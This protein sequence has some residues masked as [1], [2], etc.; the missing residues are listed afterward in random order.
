[1]TIFPRSLR[2]ACLML[3]LAAPW[4]VGAGDA[5]ADEEASRAPV[6]QYRLPEGWSAAQLPDPLRAAVAKAVATVVDPLSPDAQREASR[7]ISGIGAPALPE[8]VAA[9]AQAPWSARAALVGAVAEMDAPE[10]TPLL[11]AAAEDPAF[12]VREAAVVGLGKTGD[13]RAGAV[14]LA[15]SDPAAERVWRVRTVAAEALRRGILRGAVDRSAGEAALVRLLRDPDRDVR[16]SALTAL[17]PLGAPEALEP[18]LALHGALREDKDSPYEE[19]RLV[20]DALRAYRTDDPGVRG[21]LVD[22]FAHDEP[23]I[24]VL[25]AWA[26][27]SVHGAAALDD[28]R[29]A[30]AVLHQLSQDQELGMWEVLAGLGPDAAPWLRARAEQLALR[31]AAHRAEFHENLLLSLVELLV[32]VDEDAGVELLHWFLEGRDA[33]VLDPGTRR[34]ALDKAEAAL[35]HRMGGVLRRFFHAADGRDLRRQTLRALVRSGGD[36]VASFVDEALNSDDDALAREALDLL[37][38]HPEIPAGP[39]LAELARDSGGDL[40]RLALQTLGRRDPVAAAAVAAAS[41]AHPRREMRLE[42]AGVLA[43]ARDPAHFDA[44]LARF[45][46]EDGSDGVPAPDADPPEEADP[47]RPVTLSP[48]VS[49]AERF[50]RILRRDLLRALHGVDPARARPL[51]IESLV[52]EPDP[53]M[54]TAAARLLRE[55]TGDADAALLL[56]RAAKDDDAAVR[57]ELV[58]TLAALGDAQTVVD[59]FSARVADP[60]SRGETLAR[61][62]LSSAR[63]VPAGI[64]EGLD[65]PAW[66]DEHRE[67]ALVIL[68]RA[69]RV[70]EAEKLVALV[71][72]AHTPELTAEALRQ[73]ALRGGDRAEQEMIRLLESIEDPGK[74][75]Q[76]ARAIGEARAV[77]AVPALIAALER[78]RDAAVAAP[79]RVDPAVELYEAAAAA[80]G[81]CGGEPAGRVLLAHLLHPDLVR[82]GA[83]L[84]VLKGGPF[85]ADDPS[86]IPLVKTLVRAFAHLDE[87]AC[88][89]LVS[90]WLAEISADGRDLALDEGYVDGIARYLRDPQAYDLPPRRRPAAALLLH[91]LVLRIAPRLSPIDLE[92]LND[93]SSELSTQGRHEEALA[94]YRS[95]VAQLDVEDAARRPD[96]RTWQ[97]GKLRVLEARVAHAR[98]ETDRALAIL[99]TVRTPDPG[100]G[101]LAYLE[102]Y[103]RVKCGL[104]DEIAREALRHQLARDGRHANAAFYLGWVVEAMDGAQSAVAHYQRSRELDVKAV[105]DARGQPRT[106]RRGRTHP[107]A[108]HSYFLGRAL[109]KVGRR[110]DEAR[111]H[112][113]EAILLDDRNAAAALADPV[114]RRWDDLAG[115]V[116]EARESL[117]D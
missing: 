77:A 109:A 68:E 5:P 61:L 17:G 42:A 64:E 55:S 85:P 24:A 76:V 2:R 16:L 113:R 38:R 33:G 79:V 53:S 104:P 72:G 78:S 69:G 110:D 39:R 71:R 59:F 54:R 6:P 8:V 84:S 23:E 4:T 87:A 41:L 65:D 88:V 47:E 60:G 21:A 45:R 49:P 40:S 96:V 31:I 83:R 35:A 81:R 43:A 67:A 28:E 74:G 22:A 114:F 103:G 93:L 57:E 29:V 99:G 27:F 101:D 98:G 89:R 111:H 56:E 75:A 30:E 1:M 58:D 102:G 37:G 48:S 26:L 10:A 91:A 32:R 50:R 107:W 86:P 3:A 18:L 66:K 25:A 20:L 90:E 63:V 15:R 112:L 14:L 94:T 73:L 105:Q 70:P 7:L 92:A 97:Q 11:A 19:R 95:Y 44:L 80:L 12:A 108:F 100:N 51:V 82:V 117:R 9:L 34:I 106:H 62:R 115:L 52:R 116:R 36:D 13:P 46:E